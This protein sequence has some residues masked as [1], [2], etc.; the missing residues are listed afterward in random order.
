M[1]IWMDVDT[2]IELFVNAD[3]LV[4]SADGFTIDEGIAWNEGNM[5]LIWHFVQPDGTV[6][7]TAVTPTTGGD[8]DWAHTDGGMYKIEMTATG[9]ASANNNTEGF[10]WFTGNCDAVLPWRSPTYGFRA[11]AL[12]D[13]LIEGG[14]NL[15]VNVVQWLA[16]AV[17]LSSG[18][19]PDVNIDEIS[20]DTTAPQNLELM[21]DGTGYVG[22]TAVLHA[23]LTKMGGVAQSATDLKD[24]ADAGYDPSTDKIT[25]VKLVDTTTA[26]T[27]AEADIA[28]LFDINS[29]LSGTP[30]FGTL[31]ERTYQLLNNKMSITDSTGVVDLRAIGNGSSL[32]TWGITD[33]DTLTIKTEGSW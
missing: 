14:D 3:P 31:I 32:A 8:Y 26:A 9:G 6:S 21:Y 15:D 1:P 20:D 30:D 29:G 17:T 13:A 5:D 7:S 19:N 25:G 18:N 10:G 33:N 16:Q 11:A 24:F 27:D 4:A 23:D 12:N 28:A 2:A 22:G